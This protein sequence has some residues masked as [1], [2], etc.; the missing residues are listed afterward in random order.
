MFGCVWWVWRE[1][2]E[3]EKISIVAMRFLFVGEFGSS[4]VPFDAWV[5]GKGHLIGAGCHVATRIQCQ[6]NWFEA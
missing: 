6:S 1:W 2:T 5:A 3:V 4:Y